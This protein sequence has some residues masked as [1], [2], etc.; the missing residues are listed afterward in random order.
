MKEVADTGLLV[1]LLT[2][3]DP[4]HRWAVNAFRRHVPF[5]TCE[6]VKC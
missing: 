1:A 2:R 3:N 6:E 5:F 4:H